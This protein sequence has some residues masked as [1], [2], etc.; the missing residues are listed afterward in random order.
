MGAPPGAPAGSPPQNKIQ[1]VNPV[2]VWEAIRKSLKK[3]EGAQEAEQD[4]QE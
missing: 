2:D 1:K 4:G 3:G